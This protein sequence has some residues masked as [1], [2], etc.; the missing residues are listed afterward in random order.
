MSWKTVSNNGKLIVFP[1]G[2]EETMRVVWDE[3]TGR[4]I[5]YVVP[6]KNGED[7]DAEMVAACPELFNACRMLWDAVMDTG[8]NL[9]HG[10]LVAAF[11]CKAAVHKAICGSKPL[12]PLPEDWATAQV[13]AADSRRR[14]LSRSRQR[15]CREKKRSLRTES[16]DGTPGR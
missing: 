16:T 13:L 10:V 4:D 1:S 14:Q 6:R 9:P 2:A 15:R 11:Q 7:G 8:C 3:R 5:A 12:K